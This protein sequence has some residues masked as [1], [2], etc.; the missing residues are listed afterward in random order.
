MAADLERL[1]ELLKQH[2]VHYGDFVLASGKRSNVYV[3]CRLTTL[4]AGSQC[5]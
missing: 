2:S 3:D 5:R 4:R 1:K